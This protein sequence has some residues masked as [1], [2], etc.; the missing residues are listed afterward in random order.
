[1]NVRKIAY[2]A[3]IQSMPSA[4]NIISKSHLLDVSHK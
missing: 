3:I 1:M 2:A 4:K